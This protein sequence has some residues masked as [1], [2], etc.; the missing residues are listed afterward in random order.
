MKGALRERRSWGEASLR[1]G[2]LKERGTSLKRD[3]VEKEKTLLIKDVFI[4]RRS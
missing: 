3:V 1:R 4:K 2:V